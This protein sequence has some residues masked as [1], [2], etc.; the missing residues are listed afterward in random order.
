[1][2]SQNNQAPQPS[3]VAAASS[4][5]ATNSATVPEGASTAGFPPAG[6]PEHGIPMVPVAAPTGPVSLY[7]GDLGT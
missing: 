3:D 1:M 4:A 2:A 6:F 5:A 7:V